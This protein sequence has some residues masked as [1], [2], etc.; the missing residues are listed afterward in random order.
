MHAIQRCCWFWTPVGFRSPSSPQR[1]QCSWTQWET[2]RLSSVHTNQFAEQV[3]ASTV[4]A[5][6]RL[7]QTFW[8]TAGLRC[9]DWMFYYWDESPDQLAYYLRWRLFGSLLFHCRQILGSRPCHPV[10]ALT[11]FL[12]RK[13]RAT[14]AE[15]PARLV[16]LCSYVAL[17]EEASPPPPLKRGEWAGPRKGLRWTESRCVIHQLVKL[18]WSFPQGGNKLVWSGKRWA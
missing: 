11:F 15:K 8:K 1:Q 14:Q 16:Q 4:S 10:R 12:L 17:L 3:H 2:L 13:C 5:E 18:P 7:S 6:V 9:P